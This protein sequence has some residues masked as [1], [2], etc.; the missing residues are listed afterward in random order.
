MDFNQFVEEHQRAVFA[1]LKKIVRDYQR[2]E[3]LCQDT[4]L[5]AL[6]I[7]RRREFPPRPRMWLL[8]IARNLAFDASRRKDPIAL[9]A[10]HLAALGKA[11]E[12]AWDLASVVLEGGRHEE[13]KRSA[14]KKG[15]HLLSPS[16]REI[17]ACRYEKGMDY[18]E[19]AARKGISAQSAKLRLFRGRKALRKFM[20]SRARSSRLCSTEMAG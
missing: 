13:E 20:D 4:F 16:T 11:G 15:M 7:S 10:E 18:W 1:Y 3:D 9:E 14:L 6:Q 5:K 17:F 12:E 8:R 2:A 19:I